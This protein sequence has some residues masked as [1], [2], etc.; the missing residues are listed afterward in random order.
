MS[1]DDGRHSLTQITTSNNTTSNNTTSHNTTSR[2]DLT[3]QDCT[4]S[5]ANRGI[6]D[7]DVINRIADPVQRSRL[8]A[9]R[10]RELLRESTVD[11]FLGRGVLKSFEEDDQLPGDGAKPV[12]HGSSI[13]RV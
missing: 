11:T 6:L 1:R 9:A 8:L 5:N 12:Q 3:S 2:A 4:A 13:D 10:S 7:L